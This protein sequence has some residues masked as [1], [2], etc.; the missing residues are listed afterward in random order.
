MIKDKYL[1]SSVLLL[2]FIWMCINSCT[3]PADEQ[4]KAGP[5]WRLRK[6][7]YE[8]SQGERSLTTYFYDRNGQNYLALW[9][10]A[11]S[12]RSSV[13]HHEID[14]G[15][16]IVRKE[17]LFSDGAS[18]EQYYE[19]DPAGRLVRES[20]RRSDG[21]AGTASFRYDVNGMLVMADCK[22]LNGWF[23]GQIFYRYRRG[24]KTG[25]TIVR[26]SDTIGSIRY[27]YD[28]DRLVGE[29]WDIEG[30]LSQTFQYEYHKAATQAGVYDNVFLRE[31]PW[32]RVVDE[33]Y[34]YN[35]VNRGV[36]RYTYDAMNRLEQQEF[37]QPGGQSIH[38]SYEYDSTGLLRHSYRA[39]PEG[40]TALFNYW[41]GVRRELL[42]RTWEREDGTGGSETYRYDDR[43]L[44][45]E[46]VYEN[47]A[48][49]LNGK[50]SFTYDETGSLVSGIFSGDDG[51]DAVLTFNYDLNFNLLKIR[52]EFDNGDTQTYTFSYGS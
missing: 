48:G 23:Y 1:F 24:V 32:F 34:E 7:H 30:E 28:E 42:V 9:Q 37:L 51:R 47:V 3:R 27:D 29:S 50:L 14:T 20:F 22:G 31:S 2:F 8:N 12:S 44:L 33:N 39:Y 36:S 35:G 25:G 18:S 4:E 45:S 5:V 11:D 21:V 17:R 6:L 41:Y 19:Y 49:W 15:G 52:W 26:E 10:M 46:G 38:T 43:G 13:N 16:N 40:D